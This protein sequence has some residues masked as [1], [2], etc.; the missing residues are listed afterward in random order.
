MKLPT[1]NCAK[2]AVNGVADRSAPMLVNAWPAT[3]N[4]AAHA[5][6]DTAEKLV[7]PAGELAGE[8]EEDEPEWYGWWFGSNRRTA[9]ADCSGSSSSRMR[10]SSR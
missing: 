2:E 10:D 5:P 4:S 7:L 3:D 6:Y 8:D 1:V 9:G